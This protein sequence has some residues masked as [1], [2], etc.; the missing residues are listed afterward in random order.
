[1]A[2]DNEFNMEAAVA[3]VGSGLGFGSEDEG[4]GTVLEGESVVVPDDVTPEVTPA[5]EAPAVPDPAAAI[6]DPAAAVPKAE[7][8]KTWRAEALAEWDKLPPTVQAEVLKREED[9]FK[10]IEGYKQDAFYGKSMKN[11][12]DPYTPILQQYGVDPVAQVQ[13]LMHTN[14]VLLKGTNEE[15]LNVFRQVAKD[16]NVDL[17]AL[18]GEAPYVDPEVAA[19][20]QQLHAVQSTQQ[21][22]TQQQQKAQ[23]D[24]LEA[25][26]TAFAADP[27]RV[28]FE[29]VAN[30]MAAL[31]K[32]GV[33]KTMEEAYD[34]AVWANPVTRAKEQS[35]LQTETAAKAKKDAE[36]RA[37]A[38]R[39]AT[40]AN[41]R[42]SAKKAGA[43]TPLGSIDDTLAETLAAINARS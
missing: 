10:G 29:E 34:K 27:A 7:P 6:P 38:A 30:D 23:R 4:A 3:D 36:D 20:R 32:S 19:L 35:R 39:K 16:Y 8:P 40:S 14:H 21:Q 17:T 18:G 13:S 12:M 31:L 41:V 26:V 28:H 11:V 5:L 1:M 15:K 43:T 37:E 2:G 33:S 22:F 25:K 24:E 9:M 42:T